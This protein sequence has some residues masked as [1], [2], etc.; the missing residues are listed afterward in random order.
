MTTSLPSTEVIVADIPEVYDFSGEFVYNFFV[1]DEKTSDLAG[2]PVELLK[3]SGETLDS[4]FFVYVSRFAPR[5]TKFNFTPI[6][7]LDYISETSVEEARKDVFKKSF[8][9]LITSNLDKIINEDSMTNFSFVSIDFQDP[10][11]DEKLHNFVSGSY[12]VFKT[13]STPTSPS[14]GLTDYMLTLPMGKTSKTLVATGKDKIAGSFKDRSFKI[15]NNFFDKLKATNIQ[16]KLNAHFA[17]TLIGTSLNDPTCNF[18]E[19]LVGLYN[20]TKD[21]QESSKG[22]GAAF[23]SDDYKTKLKYISIKKADSLDSKMNAEIVGYIIDKY[24]SK[25]TA[26]VPMEPI[27]IENPFIGTFI[28]YKVKYNSTYVYAIRTICKIIFPAISEETSEL[29]MAT[30]LVSSKQ[31][32]K[33]TLNCIDTTP[34]PAPADLDFRWDYEENRLMVSWAFP[35]NPQRDIKRFQVFRRKSIK[36]PFQLIVEYN[37]DDSEA[38]S[39]IAEFPRQD[40][41]ET[42][43]SP[44]TFF[45][46]DDFV[47]T[48]DFIYTLAAIDAHGL[49]SNLSQQFE[50]TFDRFKNKIVKKLIA[51]S[52]A[53]KHYPNWFLNEDAFVDSINNS[54]FSQVKIAF[55]PDVY[56]YTNSSRIEKQI[57]AT[58]RNLG[59]YRLQMI[60]L[61]QQKQQVVDINIQDKRPSKLPAPIIFGKKGVGGGGVTKM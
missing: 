37:F 51:P 4:S 49:T 20:L 50:V 39:A 9:G 13:N 29:V 43:L 53:P 2:T 12:V 5:F 61:D 3:K 11:I 16:V 10:N 23:D 58:D 15:S 26:L 31:S 54:G 59:A 21:L 45:F 14:S 24:E 28:D 27:I 40:M 36:E 60:N 42:L 18:N 35:V 25:D 57:I 34:P 48:S 46:D 33:L 52:G 44:K 38:K 32:R 8:H 41:V 47:K 30:V 1:K 6:I 55:N 56:S 7:L 19:E 22:N 17:N